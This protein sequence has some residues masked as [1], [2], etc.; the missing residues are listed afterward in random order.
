MR[1]TLSGD[2]GSGKSTVGRRLAER[3]K[4]PHHSAGSLFREIGQ[5]S[6]LDALQTNLAAEDNVAIDAAVDNRTRELDRTVASFI[7]DSRMAWHFVTGA[8]RVYL[9]ASPETAAKRIAADTTRSSETYTSHAEALASLERRRESEVRRYKK[10]YSA[11]ITDAR[12][13]DLIIIT[14]DAEVDDIAEVIIRFAERKTQEKYWIPKRR[15]VPMIDIASVL[16]AKFPQVSHHG[17]DG[18]SLPVVISRNFGFFFDGA[19]ELAAA[20][21]HELSLVPYRGINDT[22]GG[23][24]AFKLAQRTLKSSALQR[25]QNGFKVAFSFAECLPDGASA[26]A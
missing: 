9:S 11:D 23:E 13:Y 14:D 26:R 21:E 19:R 17:A 6:N 10:L 12:N 24:D 20:L 2:L 16:T 18:S 3:L 25:W 8:A 22:P 1:I 4:L 5:I 7:I 15:L